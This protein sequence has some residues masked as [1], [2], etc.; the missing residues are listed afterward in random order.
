MC[1]NA[2]NNNVMIDKLAYLVLKFSRRASYTQCFLHTIN[3][4]AK[5]LI[6]EF[7]VTKKDAD[8]VWS[9]QAEPEDNELVDLGSDI[10]RE[11]REEVDEELEDNSEGWIDEVQ[12]MEEEEAVKL[13]RNI[14]P[15]KLVLLKV[16][17]KLH[18]LTPRLT[19]SS[20]GSS[21][22]NSFTQQLSF[23]L[24]G[25]RSCVI[26]RWWKQGCPETCPPIGIQ[27][28]TCWSI[29]STIVKQLMQWHRNGTWNCD[30]LSLLILSGELLCNC[31]FGQTTPIQ[32]DYLLTNLKVLK[33]AT[34]FFSHSTPN[35]MTVIPAMDIIDQCLTSYSC[36][37]KYL[38]SICAAVGLAKK[39]LNHYY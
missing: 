14:C 8:C 2:S 1:D 25:T 11:D 24:P 18:T 33:D 12:V 37:V 16:S 35:L 32:Y 30:S 9:V 38:P 3:L 7:D 36:N 17:Q 6:W 10:E 26:C 13:H 19:F 34:L 5:S 29:P 15:I 23:S 20:C 4:V 28:L 27:H 22:T 31:V 39:T 21:P